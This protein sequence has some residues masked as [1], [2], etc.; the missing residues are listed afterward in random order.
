MSKRE[1][2]VSVDIEASGPYPGEYSLL[3]IGACL[4]DAPEET[5]RCELKPLSMNADPKALA[6]SGLSMQELAVRGLDPNEAM[7]RFA[8]WAC[9]RAADENAELVFVG[10]NAAFDWAFVNHYFLRFLNTNPFG[11]APLDI[12]AFYMGATNCDWADARSSAMSEQLGAHLK[13]DH[14]AL[15]DAVF[16]AELFR[17]VRNY[18][19]HR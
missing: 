9:G 13:G 3:S 7:S 19:Q 16:Q 10:L 15:H 11:F 2:F 5:F 4:V 8:G 17:L 14:D 12:K 18:I 6:V 1:M